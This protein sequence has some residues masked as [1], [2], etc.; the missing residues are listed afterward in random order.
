V[1]IGTSLLVS[2]GALAV[3]FEARADWSG[4]GTVSQIYSHNGYHFII[5]TIPDAPCG[6]AGRFWWPTNDPDAKDLFAMAMTALVAD[7]VIQV[8]YNGISCESAGF[9]LVTHM[10]I[11]K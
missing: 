6:V 8:Y 2:V 4:I 10:V 9:E 7:K 1:T 3:P 11:I 5:T